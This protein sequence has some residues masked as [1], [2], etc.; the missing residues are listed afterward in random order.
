MVTEKKTKNPKSN[1]KKT[2]CYRAIGPAALRT[3]AKTPEAELVERK[4]SF[5]LRCQH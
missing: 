3:K 2:V 4:A 1:E 5:I